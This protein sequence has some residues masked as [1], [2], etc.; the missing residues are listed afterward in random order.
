MK[1]LKSRIGTSNYWLSMH[2]TFIPWWRKFLR[3]LVLLKSSFVN[4]NN[5]ETVPSLKQIDEHYDATVAHLKQEIA[6]TNA[7]RDLCTHYAKTFWNI[8][9]QWKSQC[10]LSTVSS[11]ARPR[12]LKRYRKPHRC[13]VKQ[14]AGIALNLK[15]HFAQCHKGL[16]KQDRTAALAA[17]DKIKKIGRLMAKENPPTE[18]GIKSKNKMKTYHRRCKFCDKEFKRIDVHLI[19][20]HLLKRGSRELRHSLRECPLLEK[21]AEET[22]PSLTIT[23]ESGELELS[24][25]DS[26]SEMLNQFH[27]Y[28]KKYTPLKKYTAMKTVR[29]AA[30]FINASIGRGIM[31]N[32][33][34]SSVFQAFEHAA[35]EDGYFNEK[36]A[37]FSAS[38]L[39]KIVTSLKKFVEFMTNHSTIRM[40][41]FY[42]N[43]SQNIK[44]CSHKVSERRRK[45]TVR[46][47]NPE[48]A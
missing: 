33:S 12:I 41:H 20:V 34:G 13:P 40:S 21:E 19:K 25:K 31:E 22:Q 27:D 47:T 16:T 32:L 15:R 37:V 23:V 17:Y 29:I 35:G 11:K 1:V 28:L 48:I 14:C 26:F 9:G 2:Q 10:V 42:E 46:K 5:L 30:N 36:R 4:F 24:I 43:K 7:K 38:Y 3:C 44:C 45:R 8:Y 18:K 6:K 39:R